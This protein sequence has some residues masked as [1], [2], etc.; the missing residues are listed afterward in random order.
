VSQVN[1]LSRVWNVRNSRT[2]NRHKV[3]S[4]VFIEDPTR[5]GKKIMKRVIG[6]TMPTKIMADHCD[7]G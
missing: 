5:F 3:G 4:I 1:V 6:L 7:H 2:K